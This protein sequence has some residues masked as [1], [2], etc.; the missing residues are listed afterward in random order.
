MALE[1]HTKYKVKIILIYGN[2]KMLSKQFLSQRG[3]N[4]NQDFRPLA[5]IQKWTRLACSLKCTQRKFIKC[6][7]SSNN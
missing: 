6:N 4:K 3:G 7:T 1:T 2:F 5:Q